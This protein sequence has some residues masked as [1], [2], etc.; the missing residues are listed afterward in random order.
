MLSCPQ[1]AGVD[2]SHKQGHYELSCSYASSQKPLPG[3]PGI[4]GQGELLPALSPVLLAPYPTE[5]WCSP[6]GNSWGCRFSLQPL[7]PGTLNHLLAPTEP[8]KFSRIS[9]FFSYPHQWM[10]SSPPLGLK[11]AL[12]LSQ[13]GFS[14]SGFCSHLFLCVLN[15]LKNFKKFILGVQTTWRVGSYFPQQGLNP[16]PWLWKCRVLTSGPPENSQETDLVS[17]LTFLVDTRRGE[18]TF[19]FRSSVRAFR[20]GD[21][22]VFGCSARFVGC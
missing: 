1:L 20:V 16:G 2:L 3:E 10:I 11:E 12:Y 4:P 17:Y 13:A 18:D 21:N 14:L 22:F 8:Y 6:K 9:C 5:P 19:L 7:L 15:F